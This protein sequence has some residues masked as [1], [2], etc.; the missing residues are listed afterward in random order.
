M[1]D[2]KQ[3]DWN[4][5]KTIMANQLIIIRNEDRAR[6]YSIAKKKHA[7]EKVGAIKI[8]DEE[9]NINISN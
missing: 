3:K 6:G 9:I 2:N 7:I 8:K 1:E 4:S 5:F